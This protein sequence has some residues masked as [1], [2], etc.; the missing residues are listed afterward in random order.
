MNRLCAEATAAAVVAQRIYHRA[1]GQ[2]LA[3]ELLWRGHI[4]WAGDTARL[5]ALIDGVHRDAARLRQAGRAS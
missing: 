3:E 1:V 5:Q 2:V 4:S